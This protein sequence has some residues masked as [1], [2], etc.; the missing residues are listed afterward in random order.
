MTESER[1]EQKQAL[2]VQTI[3]LLRTKKDN[4][5]INHAIGM[6]VVDGLLEVARQMALSREENQPEECEPLGGKNVQ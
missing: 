5:F 4:E 1:L 2:F 6:A 3:Q